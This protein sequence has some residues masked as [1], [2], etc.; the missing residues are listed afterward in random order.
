MLGGI[1][2]Q[3]EGDRISGDEIG[4]PV[5]V[6]RRISDVTMEGAPEIGV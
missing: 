6:E 4:D 1:G 5:G 3:R 2:I